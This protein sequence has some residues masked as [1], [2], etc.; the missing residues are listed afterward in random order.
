MTEN[1]FE[2]DFDVADEDEEFD[3]LFDA[4]EE[5]ELEWEDVEPEFEGSTEFLPPDPDEFAAAAGPTLPADKDDGRPAAER[6]NELF[7]QM[8]PRKQI[9]LDTLR[10]AAVPI[11]TTDINEVINK[12]EAS[13]YSVYSPEQQCAML[14]NAGALQRVNPDGTPYSNEEREPETVIVDG[15]AYLQ[16]TQPP[17]VYWLITEAGQD[18]VDAD[19]PLERFRA[20]VLGDS[21]FLDAYL[22]IMESCN[23]EKGAI[24]TVLDKQVE[25]LPSVCAHTPKFTASHFIDRL[26]LCNTVVWKRPAWQ[27]TDIGKEAL[28]ELKAT[29]QEPY[30]AQECSNARA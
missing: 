19:K 18:V 7:H 25:E 1:K 22:C 30:E 13:N 5:E 9:F 6:I 15:V 10:A 11:S 12:L 20:N 26:R 27:L 8:V 23:T 28:V 2:L 16:P 4:K 17:E 14:E 3:P 29:L 24:I 21:E